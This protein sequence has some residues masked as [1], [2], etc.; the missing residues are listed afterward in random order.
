M[1]IVIGCLPAQ[2]ESLS[3]STILSDQAISLASLY[4]SNIWSLCHIPNGIT[5]STPNHHL[6]ISGSQVTLESN[7]YFVFVNVFFTLVVF[8]NVYFYSY[9]T[10]VLGVCSINHSSVITLLIQQIMLHLKFLW[11]AWVQNT[12]KFGQEGLKGQSDI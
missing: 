1:H 3:T 5:H 11:K 2:L 12:S 9:I 10:L 4:L 6:I 7:Y 8:V